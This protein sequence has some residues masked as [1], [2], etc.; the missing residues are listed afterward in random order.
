MSGTEGAHANA[1]SFDLLRRATQAMMSRYVGSFFLLLGITYH[2][3]TSAMHVVF[4]MR[5]VHLDSLRTSLHNHLLV[6]AAFLSLC[7]FSCTSEYSSTIR[8]CRLLAQKNPP[9]FN[10]PLLHATEVTLSST[11]LAVPVCCKRANSPAM[12]PTCRH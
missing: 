6:V 10:E 11:M 1:G 12:R 9:H 2:L 4:F 8:H 7:L 3:T 5:T